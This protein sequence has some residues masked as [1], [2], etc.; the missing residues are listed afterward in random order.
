MK[1]PEYAAQVL[2]DS[3]EARLPAKLAA[4]RARLDLADPIPDGD[5]GPLPDPVTFAARDEGALGW[6]KFPAILVIAQTAAGMERL[7][8]VD[9]VQVYRVRYPVRVFSWLTGV[10]YTESDLR[11]K[12]YAL[13]VRELLLAQSVLADD[14]NLDPT[15]LRESYSDIAELADE[16]ATASQIVAALYTEV[17]VEVKELL[18]P[19]LGVPP[20]ATGGDLAITPA[21]R[22]TFPE[23]WPV[24]VEEDYQAV[25]PA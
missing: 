2:L 18:E 25:P 22:S 24:V 8:E 7:D 15:G 16:T 6:E 1:G 9:G 5:P 14:A 3:V 4:I 19:D 23:G 17:A 10:D 11:R 13:A 21:D 12:R 20:A